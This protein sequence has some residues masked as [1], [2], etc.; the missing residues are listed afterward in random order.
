VAYVQ[1]GLPVLARINANN[2]LVGLIEAEGVGRVDTGT[3]LDSLQAHAEK[4]AGD[5]R[6][7]EIMSSNGRQLARKLFSPTAA[8]RQIVAALS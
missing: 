5:P 8:V 4:M 1:A 3:T 7:R 6:R 2:D